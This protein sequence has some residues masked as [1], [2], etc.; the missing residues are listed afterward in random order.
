[1]KAVGRIAEQEELL[2]YINSGSPE[3]VAVYG[4]RRV[5]KTFLIREYFENNFSFYVTGLANEKTKMQLKNFNSALLKYGKTAYPV[6][7]TWFEAFEQLI[8]LLEKKQKKGRKVIFLDELPWMD[9][10]KSG[11]ITAFE[12]FW[13][14]WASAR[15]E[16]LLIV[17]GSATSWMVNKLIKNHGGLHNR[18]TRQMYLKP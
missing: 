7:N 16:I 5:G 18:V 6:A 1:M 4:R 13:N 15:P 9:T 11:F 17:C 2:K 3:F 10:H 8:H 12:H 14:S